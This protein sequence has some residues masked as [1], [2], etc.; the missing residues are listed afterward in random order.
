M[1][2]TKKCI[3]S[4]RKDKDVSLALVLLVRPNVNNLSLVSISSFL[5]IKSFSSSQKYI[6]IPNESFYKIEN[7]IKNSKNINLIL[8]PNSIAL[9]RSKLKYLTSKLKEDY[10]I[11][12]HD[13]DV[14]SSQLI[15]KPMEI[16]K[17]HSPIALALHVTKVDKDLKIFKGRRSNNSKKIKK[18]SPIKILE[19]YFLP[20]EQTPILPA[21]FFRRNELI[22]YWKE[23][24]ITIG[25][26]EDA[27]MNY[28]LSQRGS[29]LEWENPNLYFYRN[30]NSQD[31]SQRNEFDR[32]RLIAWLKDLKLNPIYKIIFL[33]SSKL[34]YFIFYKKIETRVSYLSDILKGLRSKLIRHRIGGDTSKELRISD[35]N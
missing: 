33:A 21:I 25:S 4:E 34:Q 18:L 1:I 35:Y 27:K 15:C 7:S 11:I 23:N 10:V 6:S 32:L 16:L 30:H 26:H 8:Q 12:V 2:R 17:K 24:V 29:F 31:S 22:K 19:R 3:S 28:N 5:K 20:F 13:D 9:G 14:Y